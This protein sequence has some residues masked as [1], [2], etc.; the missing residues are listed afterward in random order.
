MLVQRPS[1]DFFNLKPTIGVKMIVR[2]PRAIRSG[3][4]AGFPYSLSR[5]T[6][7]PVAKWAWLKEAMKEG[8]MIGFD[9]S[10][11]VP[12]HWSLRPDDT[13]GLVFWTK[14]P[15]NLIF[16]N[17][18]DRGYKI[19]VHVTV[20]GWEEVEKGAPSLR[21]GANSLGMAASVFKPENVFW[22]FSPVPMVPDVVE[23]FDTIL[24]MAA[25]HGL[26]RVYLSFLQDNDLMPETRTDQ[27]RINVLVQI[28]ERAERRGVRVLLCNEDRFLLGHPELHPNLGS[29]VCAPP[30]D[31]SMQGLQKPPSEGCGCVL[32]VDPFTI[33]ETCTM[34]CSYCYAA[35][36]SLSPKRRN[37]TRSLPVVP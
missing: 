12:A 9:P 33:N 35:D 1:Q 34:G 26:Q 29:G 6:D 18:Q 15:T 21:A 4:E 36:K 10:T 13:L 23:R 25:Y 11:G 27:E 14:D 37:T 28:A 22:R 19:K 5:W 3:K 7:V 30:E 16:D 17:P 24:A 32:M 2:P 8:R 20:T 31:F